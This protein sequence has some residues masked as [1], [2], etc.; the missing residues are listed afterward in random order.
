MRSPISSDDIDQ[1]MKRRLINVSIYLIVEYSYHRD[2]LTVGEF[3]P[4]NRRACATS[5]DF[6]YS[7]PAYRDTS[8]SPAKNN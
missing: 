8:R 2:A 1:M 7:R 4:N 5:W 3:E 6:T